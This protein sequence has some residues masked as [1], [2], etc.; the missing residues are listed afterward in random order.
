[1]SKWVDSASEVVFQGISVIQKFAPLLKN[2]VVL[3]AEKE[4]SYGFLNEGFCDSLAEIA[5]SQFP[6]TRN[7]IENFISAQTQVEYW[8]KVMYM[9]LHMLAQ[10]CL[11]STLDLANPTKDQLKQRDNALRRAQVKGGS[12]PAVSLASLQTQAT[13]SAGT[14]T[15]T[16]HRDLTVTLTS[17]AHA[18]ME[19]HAKSIEAWTQFIEQLNETSTDE[20]V[21]ELIQALEQAPELMR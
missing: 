12:A 2:D 19:L 16:L 8:R 1:M 17:F 15:S 6:R 4:R 10:S 5:T 7:L 3:I 18:Q 20:D 9:R 21:T 13:Q 11:S 14:F